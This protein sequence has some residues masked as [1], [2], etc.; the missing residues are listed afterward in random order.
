[1]VHGRQLFVYSVWGQRLGNRAFAAHAD[2]IFA[3]LADRF[4]DPDHGG[5]HDRTDLDGNVT[6]TDKLL[7]SHAFV[8]LGLTAYAYCLGR[9]VGPHLDRTLEYIERRFR[10]GAGLYHSALDRAGHDISES[11]DQNPLMHLLEAL[12]LLGERAGRPDA[13]GIARTIVERM[14]VSF[15]RGGL[16]VEH[17][18]HDLEPHPDHGHVAEPGHPAEW[19][20]LLDWYGRLAGRG[21]LDALCRTLL[22]NGMRHGWDR[23]HT[24]LFDRID[25]IS[26]QAMV[27]TKRL[28]PL[29]ETIKAASVFP[30][31]VAAAGHS[32]DLL[33]GLLC[34]CYLKPDGTRAE[35]LHR[36]MTV[37]DP[38]LPASTCYHLSFALAEALK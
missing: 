2:R 27:T 10:Y 12:L 13:L 38:C 21:D 26:G 9:D 24:G 15:L 7:Y 6:V 25:R 32:V 22:S 37:A 20:W 35:R 29:A 1:M 34:H 16:V 23:E 11:V 31:C 28:W 19:A 30:D 3:Y 14:Q 8:L 33:I 18:G 17:L 36:D 4:A 5:W